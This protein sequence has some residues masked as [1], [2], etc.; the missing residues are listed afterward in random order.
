MSHEKIIE[1]LKE[2]VKNN[3]QKETS[4]DWWHVLRVYNN[5]LSIAEKE[6]GVNILIVEIASLLHDI[7]DHKFGHTD[8]DRALIITNILENLKIEPSII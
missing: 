1:K 2:T 6:E 5:A 3:L 4:H 8:N 7:A